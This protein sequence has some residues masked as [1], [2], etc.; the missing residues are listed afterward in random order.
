MTKQYHDQKRLLIR[1]GGSNRK[2]DSQLSAFD[3]AG[4]E[5]N[6]YGHTTGHHSNRHALIPNTEEARTLLKDIGGTVDRKQW[7]HLKNE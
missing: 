5:I 2:L 3:F 4:I 7:E 1:I 6:Q